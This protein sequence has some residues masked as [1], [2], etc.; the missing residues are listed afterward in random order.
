[1]TGDAYPERWTGLQAV[2]RLPEHLDV[3]SAAQVSDALLAAIN[4]GA[5][6]LTADMTATVSCDHAGADALV[7]VYKRAV[8]SG[9]RFRLVIAAPVVRRVLSLSGIDRVVP[10]YPSMEAAAA[11]LV[12]APG[13]APAWTPITV[14]TGIGGRAPT[15]GG[16]RSA[17]PLPVAVALDGDGAAITAEVLRRVLD[18]LPDGVALA[19]GHGSIM[20]ASRRLEEMFGYG[21]GELAGRPVAALRPANGQAAWPPEPGHRPAG[22]RTPLAGLRKDGTTFPAEITIS[23]VP[24]GAGHFAVMIR[25]AT[26]ALRPGDLAGLAS[27]AA[28]QQEH[29]V[30]DLLDTVITSLFA[31]GLSLQAAADPLAT[32]A[33]D[34]ITAVLGDLDDAIRTIRDTMF[35]TTTTTTAAA[36]HPLAH[37]VTPPGQDTHA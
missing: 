10:V 27:A 13:P 34:R 26:G 23:P 21:R 25:E 2:V 4:R 11:A 33:G 17:G 36:H 24:A 32:A 5:E 3:S 20:L 7:R 22:A 18:V 16:R 6:A 28:T 35:T 14:L 9:T 12:P 37:R 30:R 19:D 8:V 1:V 29:R 15:G 31:A